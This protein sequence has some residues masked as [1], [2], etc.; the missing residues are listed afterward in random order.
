MN[1]QH[2]DNNNN[3]NKQKKKKNNNNNTKKNNKNKYQTK[4][5]AQTLWKKKQK[6][7]WI[8]PWN[9]TVTQVQ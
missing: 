5:D 8:E 4:N 2:M 6:R 3:N 1:M 9:R 7:V